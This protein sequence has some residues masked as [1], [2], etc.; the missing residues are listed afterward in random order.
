MKTLFQ[1]RPI[2]FSA[3]LVCALSSQAGAAFITNG[4]FESGFSTLL[5]PAMSAGVRGE[6]PR[7][8]ANIV[9]NVS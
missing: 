5:L 9:R 8:I 1:L 7:G 2:W 4:G 3:T 6:A